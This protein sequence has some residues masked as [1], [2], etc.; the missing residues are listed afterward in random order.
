[1]KYKREEMKREADHGENEGDD[2][3]KSAQDEIRKS[4]KKGHNDLT[5]QLERAY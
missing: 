5:T 4:L 1:M 2:Y 3:F